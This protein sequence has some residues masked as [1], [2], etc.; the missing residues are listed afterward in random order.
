M[1]VEDT[2][3]LDLDVDLVEYRALGTALL[4]EHS[5]DHPITL[6]L[7]RAA[8]AA[9]ATPPAPLSIEV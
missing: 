3:D 4:V 5:V 6:Q 1:V 7:P 2:L 8:A 9:I